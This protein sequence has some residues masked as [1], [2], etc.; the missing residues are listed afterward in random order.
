MLGIGA[1]GMAGAAILFLL[2]LHA[3]LIVLYGSV[4]ALVLPLFLVTLQG[5]VFDGINAVDPEGTLFM[6]HIIV[7]EALENAGRV[8]GIA[9]FLLLIAPHPTGTRIAY[10]AF[11]LGLVQIITW[12]LLWRGGSVRFGL[13]GGKSRGKVMPGIE[14]VST[15]YL[16]NRVRG[17]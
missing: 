7:R 4:I 2:P 1:F 10:F 14:Q 5:I 15:V 11:A 8:T 12:I 9:V 6:E 3:S 13:E 17:S 16:R